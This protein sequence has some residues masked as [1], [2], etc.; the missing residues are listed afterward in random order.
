CSGQS[1]MEMGVGICNVPNEIAAADFP[2]IRLLTVPHHIVTAPVQTLE[3]RWSQCSP[4]TVA[5]GGWGGFS[6]AGFFFGLESY[7]E[8]KNPIGLIH[9]SWGGTIAEAWTSKEALQPLGDFNERLESV[10]KR[11]QPGA[12]DFASEYDKWCERN[13]P[14]TKG[15]WAKP[16]TDVTSWKTV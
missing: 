5:Q 6:A 3:C 2:Q 12:F 1:N 13:D 11:S 14:G 4:Q 7:R 8:V 9:R 15:G 10:S 16:E